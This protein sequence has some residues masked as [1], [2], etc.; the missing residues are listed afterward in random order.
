MPFKANKTFPPSARVPGYRIIWLLLD[1]C[2]IK[3]GIC[4]P[5]TSLRGGTWLKVQHMLRNSLLSRSCL[6]QELLRASPWSA[7]RRLR[8]RVRARFECTWRRET[9]AAEQRCWITSEQRQQQRYGPP[10]GCTLKY[11]TGRVRKGTRQLP[12]KLCQRRSYVTP[13]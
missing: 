3:G 2:G 9:F 11:D 7:F 12:P 1:K 6:M 13:Q 4:S 10:R 8:A 5:R